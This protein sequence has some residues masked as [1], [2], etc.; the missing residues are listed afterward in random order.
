MYAIGLGSGFIPTDSLGGE[1]SFKGH[2]NG[3]W[4]Y[5]NIIGGIILKQVL[6]R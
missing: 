2:T 3:I 4:Y 1:K 5:Q 6:N